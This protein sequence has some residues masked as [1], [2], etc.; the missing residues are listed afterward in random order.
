MQRT[1]R[2]VLPIVLY[3]FL[4]HLT[5][6]SIGCRNIYS[7]SDLWGLFTNDREV[8]DGIGNIVGHDGG[9]VG[10]GDLALEGNAYETVYETGTSPARS[11]IVPY[12]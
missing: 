6:C 11:P 1:T 2:L 10:P 7:G 4:V 5:N 12:L 8:S 3:L 9:G